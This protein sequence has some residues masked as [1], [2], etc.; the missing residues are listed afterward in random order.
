MTTTSRSIYTIGGTVQAGRGL[1]IERAADAELLA[2]CRAGAFAYVLTARQIGKSSLMSETAARLEDEGIRTV[3]IGVAIPGDL[4]KDT[5]RTPFN[6]GRQVQL[7]D[8]SA[9][10]AQRFVAG[11][12]L[13]HEAADAALARV[14]HWTSG[15]P[16]LTQRLCAAI[17]ERRGDDG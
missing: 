1:Y 8:F 9:A 15:H 2:L 13:V 7:N 17:A 6:I 5:Q 3:L 16:Y 10:E 12:G 11:L 14:L 4:I